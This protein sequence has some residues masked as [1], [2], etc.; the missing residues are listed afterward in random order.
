MCSYR[1][2]MD[3]LIPGYWGPKEK[4]NLLINI[5]KLDVILPLLLTQ[6]LSIIINKK[7]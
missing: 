2:E 5:P 3:E 7:P 4:V 6:N 1:E